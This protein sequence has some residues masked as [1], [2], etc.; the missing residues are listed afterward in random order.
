MFYCTGRCLIKEDGRGEVREE[1]ARCERM[2]SSAWVG[3]THAKHTS[4]AHI[5]NRP[6]F[7]WKNAD[8]WHQCCISGSFI[9]SGQLFTW[10]PLNT[11]PSRNP[12]SGRRTAY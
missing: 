2:I 1:G 10:G 12:T 3:G 8:E 4:Y 6:N 7:F 11:L 5:M 9:Y